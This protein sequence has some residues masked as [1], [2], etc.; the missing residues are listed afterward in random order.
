FAKASILEPENEDYRSSLEEA[1][2]DQAP[3]VETEF[4]RRTVQGE[5]GEDLVR[6]IGEQVLGHALKLHFEADQDAAFIAHVLSPSGTIAPFRGVARRGEASVQYEMEN[7]LRIEGDLYASDA[8]PGVGTALLRP[9][10]QGSTAIRLE[11]G[12]SYWEF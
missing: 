1:A 2:R 12:R 9:D 6:I 4:L 10:A 8:G 3:H 11:L 7:G 5:E